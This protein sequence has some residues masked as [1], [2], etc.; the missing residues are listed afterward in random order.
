MRSSV[1]F[2]PVRLRKASLSRSSRYCSLTG[3]PGETDSWDFGVGAG[4]DKTTY[5]QIKKAADA[6][7]GVSGEVAA[8]GQDTAASG[9]HS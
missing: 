1:F 5:N 7:T 3:V 8:I 9:G 2:S 4:K 6:V